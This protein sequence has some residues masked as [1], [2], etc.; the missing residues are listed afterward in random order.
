MKRRSVM[1]LAGAAL[2]CLAQTQRVMR[3]GFLGNVP[4]MPPDRSASDQRD[5]RFWDEMKR[6]GWE[7]GL[8]VDVESRWANNDPDK[9]RTF[10]QEFVAMRVDVIYAVGDD[11]LDGGA[12]SS[13]CL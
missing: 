12:Y 6:L 13:R 10:A 2:P 9:Y 3:I 11:A 5:F 1:C 8:N 4:A 7:P